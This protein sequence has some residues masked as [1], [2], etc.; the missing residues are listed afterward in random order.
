MG[1]IEQIMKTCPGLPLVMHGSSSV[2]RE[3][4]DLINKYGGSMPNAWVSPKMRF[5]LLLPSLAC[6]K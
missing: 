4:I 1:R 5:T 6:A 3:F 2:P